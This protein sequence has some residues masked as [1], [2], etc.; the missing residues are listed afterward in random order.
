MRFGPLKPLPTLRKGEGMAENPTV[1]MF[2]G[3]DEVE[4]RRKRQREQEEPEP[5]LWY[6]MMPRGWDC[7]GHDDSYESSSCIGAKYVS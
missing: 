4:R 5:V 2:V 6:H 3:D 1:G 7:P